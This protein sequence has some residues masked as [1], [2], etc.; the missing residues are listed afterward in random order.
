MPL[1]E[2][3]S[4]VVATIRAVLLYR[5]EGIV[6]LPKCKDRTISKQ[7]FMPVWATRIP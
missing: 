6:T 7:G 3:V 2:N 4:G 5:S 1:I